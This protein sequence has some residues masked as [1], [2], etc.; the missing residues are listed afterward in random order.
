VTS[1]ERGARSLENETM[2]AAQKSRI[3]LES[4]C[5]GDERSLYIEI[6]APDARAIAAEIDDF[7]AIGRVR[8]AFRPPANRCRI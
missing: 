7:R 5:P 4:D 8:G 3:S 2:A 6:R 1:T